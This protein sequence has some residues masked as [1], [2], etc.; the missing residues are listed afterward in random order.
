MKLLVGV[1]PLDVLNSSVEALEQ[2]LLWAAATATF[3]NSLGRGQWMQFSCQHLNTEKTLVW[4][5]TLAHMAFIF[6]FSL[7]NIAECS[8]SDAWVIGA[9]VYLYLSTIL[10]LCFTLYCS[11][12]LVAS[13]PV[14]TGGLWPKEK[15]MRV[16]KKK[17][18]VLCRQMVLLCAGKLLP[19]FLISSSFLK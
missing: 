9:D 14:N 15:Q 10:G 5:K 8:C 18:L 3:T 13:V 19:S 16:K 17:C 4:S 6:F 12:Y 2:H 11:S 7:A 1:S